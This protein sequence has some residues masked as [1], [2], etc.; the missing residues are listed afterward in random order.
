MFILSMFFIVSRVMSFLPVVHS[1]QY[2]DPVFQGKRLLM[3]RNTW[4]IQQKV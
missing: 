3:E 2:S 1:I 4:K